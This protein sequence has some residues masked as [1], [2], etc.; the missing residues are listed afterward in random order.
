MK[1]SDVFDH[2][3]DWLKADFHLHTK[4][5]K[6]FHFLGEP[7]YFVSQYVN[8]LQQQNIK[9]GVITNHNKFDIDEFKELCKNAGKQGI[10]LVPGVEF[11]IRDGANGIH[12]L[13]AFEETWINNRE[14]KNY[15]EQFLTAAFT[16]RSNYDIPPYSLSNYT[17]KNTC[18]ILDGFNKEYFMIMAHVDEDKGM[19]KE[20]NGSGLREL[21][22]SNAFKQKVLGMQQS[23]NR[24]N[25]KK[26]E[27]ILGEQ[28]PAYV[29]GSDAAHEGIDGI[30]NKS[31]VFLKLGDY[32]FSVLQ[33]ALRDHANRVRME[34]PAFKQTYLKTLHIT[35]KKL[36][37]CSL[38]LNPSMNNIIGIR[39]SGKSSLLET[40][41]YAL[42]LPLA[43]NAKDRDYKEV[44]VRELLGSG[45]KITM[46][47]A[48]AKGNCYRTEKIF[49]ETSNIYFNGEL[50][51]NLKVNAIIKPVYFGQK[52]LAE[53]GDKAT[54]E[55]LITKLIGDKLL[56]ITDKIDQQ[57]MDIATQLNEISKLEKLVTFKEDVEAKKAEIENKLKLYQENEIDKKLNRQIEFEKDKNRLTNILKFEQILLQALKELWDDYKGAFAEHTHYESKENREN[58]TEI[59]ASLGRFQALFNQIGGLLGAMEKESGVLTEL[60]DV[61]QA[62]YLVLQEEFSQIKREI[63][64][65]NIEADIYVQLSKELDLNKIK[66]I[67]INKAYTKKQEYEGKLHT[68]LVELQVL[69]H[70]EYRLVEQEIGKLNSSQVSIEIR[71]EYKGN[72]DRFKAFIKEHVKG[73]GLK[74]KAITEM[75]E[76]FKDMTEIYKEVANDGGRLKTLVGESS[77]L[78]IKDKLMEKRKIFLTYRVPDRYDIYFK[79]KPIHEHSLGQRASALILFILTLKEQ[80]IIIIDQPEDDLDNQTIYEDVI[81]A[82]NALKCEAQFIFATHN[83]NIPVLG[84]CEQVINC[85]FANDKISLASGSIDVPA[86]QNKIIEIM[87]GGQEAF[88]KRG[89]IYESWKH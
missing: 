20:L 73:S 74:D 44:I 37:D 23:R 25:R 77:Y 63:N 65:P 45:G 62:K 41:R 70:Q 11:S 5:D 68:R 12:I 76:E 85:S 29:E 36:V 14:N 8:Q 88:S 17:L 64:L 32:N 27:D 89:R 42:D 48:D 10:Y 75:V 43:K 50:Q 16:G 82:L 67:E 56:T 83:P 18:Q 47:I 61:L 72:K 60:K 21:L 78:I 30:G 80:D 38:C 81:K 24:E 51:N 31:N 59:Y 52:D 49:G 2:G 4:A 87:E 9:I 66:L 55:E 40:I 3:T 28:S 54:R 71:V 15:I 19:F 69:W 34:P 22:T 39:G 35:G 57:N 1:C 7:N 84:D 58:F 6:E 53:M 79:G 46:E 26:M 86:I 13:I 33:Y